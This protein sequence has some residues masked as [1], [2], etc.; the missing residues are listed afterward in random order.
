MLLVAWACGSQNNLNMHADLKYYA[1]LKYFRKLAVELVTLGHLLK[2]LSGR[3]SLLHGFL[4]CH[5]ACSL[6]RGFV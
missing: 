5:F 4:D 6:L 2:G 1:D 3:H